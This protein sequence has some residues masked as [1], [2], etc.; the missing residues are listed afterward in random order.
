MRNVSLGGGAVT[1]NSIVSTAHAVTTGKTATGTAS[2]T[3]NGM[4]VGG[5]PV[6][7]DDKG[8]HIDGQGQPLPSLDALHSM[9]K[10]PG[11]QLVVADPTKVIKG[12]S[13]QLFSGQLIFTQDNPQ[14][15]SSLNDSKTVVTL[16]GASIR[17][18]SSL[19]YVY[20]AGP[21]PLP[22]ANLPPPS[23][24]GG[25]V[26]AATTGGNVPAGGDGPPPPG[27]A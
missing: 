7:L 21:L 13:A 16:G 19:A 1:M 24:S 12:A 8:V 10:Q 22:A 4:K 2:T 20:N 9:L 26:P 25:N 18:D 3:V 14:Y 27:A 5:V 15:A 11:F 23:T 6:T 17:A